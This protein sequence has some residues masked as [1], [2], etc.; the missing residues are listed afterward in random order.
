MRR[1]LLALLILVPFILAS[2]ETGE[3]RGP[4]GISNVIVIVVDTLAA[5]NL[6]FMGYERDTSPF[7]N[8][9]AA[10][11]VVFDRAYTPKSTT[12][13][14]I[15]SLLSGLHPVNHGV[16]ENGTRIPDNLHFLTDNFRDAGFA[17]WGI[18]SARVIGAQYGMNRGFD[19]YSNTP[20][21]PHTA[22]EIIARVDRLLSGTGHLGEPNYRST[23]QP[24]FMMVHFYD[25]HT[26]FT[27]DEIDYEEYSDPAYSGPVNGTWEQFRLFNEYSLEFTSS[28]LREVRDLY[29]ADIKSFD[30]RLRILFDVFSDAGLMDN[31]LI[32]LTADHGENLG[33]HHFITHGHPYE[34]SLNIPLLFH[35][36]GDKWGSTRISDLVEI[37][38]I[39]P[40]IMEF[41]GIEIPPGLDGSSLRPLIDPE[42]A[43][44]YPERECLFSIG[45]PTTDGRTYAVF[46]GTMRLVVTVDEFG[47]IADDSSK[48]LF[49]IADDPDESVNV[50]HDTHVSLV[51]LAPALAGHLRNACDGQRPEVDEQTREM[52][53]SLGYL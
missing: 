39:I 26:P 46:D 2:G 20:A 6:G 24:V 47:G 52:L 16:I 49:S 45:H 15:T 12:V 19:Y 3:V 11:S 4:A 31:S 44:I 8:E 36:P 28:D 34:A 37:T 5:R 35:F 21:I 51:S 27:P 43:G 53:A 40:T 38:D 18:P 29:D 42:S 48:M 41:A 14:A 7:M 33:E 32:V 23:D 25:T 30:R 17:T 13:P 9:L 10:R 1:L 50:F 22:F